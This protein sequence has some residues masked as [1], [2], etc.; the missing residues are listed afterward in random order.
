MHPFK[1]P[2]S[3]ILR[4]TVLLFRDNSRV[5]LELMRRRRLES[6]VKRSVNLVDIQTNPVI[7]DELIYVTRFHFHC[8]NNLM[9]R[10][11]WGEI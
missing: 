6:F 10:I 11:R 4:N 5:N 8:I 2:L 3:L 1:I 7:H 9:D